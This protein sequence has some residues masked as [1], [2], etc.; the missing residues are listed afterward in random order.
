MREPV[1]GPRGVGIT[2]NYGTL[3]ADA[4]AERAREAGA[5]IASGPVDTPWNAREVTVLD[6]DGYRLNFTAPRSRDTTGGA[7]AF[8]ALVA[9]MRDGLPRGAGEAL[10]EGDPRSPE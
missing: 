8:D 4:I 1:A 7:A 10:R 9:R 5:T 6:P 3:D 2:L